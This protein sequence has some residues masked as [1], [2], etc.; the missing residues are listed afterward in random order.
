VKR[1][2]PTVIRICRFLL[3]GA[4]ANV[5]VAWGC[6]YWGSVSYPSSP[7]LGI[8][9]NQEPP[10]PPPDFS[11]EF[12]PEWRHEGRAF[13]E[14]RVRFI[15]DYA[16]KPLYIAVEE[17]RIGWPLHCLYGEWWVA[18]GPPHG[19]PPGASA[20]RYMVEVPSARFHY[21]FAWLQCGPASRS[22]RCSM[23]GF[24]G[25]CSPR[26]WRCG[27][28]GASSVACAQCAGTIYVDS[29]PLLARISAP[30]AG[31]VRNTF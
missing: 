14:Q 27:D 23:R 17:D 2:A 1:W 6:A 10:Q 24:C 25:C 29:L 16:H 18:I 8:K 20:A 3:L 31:R 15:D 22:I 7:P 9:P 11:F 12:T 19:G 28:A 4:I 5:A 21:R 26:R 13:G 30:N